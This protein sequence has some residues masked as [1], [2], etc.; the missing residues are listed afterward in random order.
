VHGGKHLQL[1]WR[2]DGH[3]MRVYS[4]PGTPGDWRSLHNTRAQIRRL[5]RADGVLTNP[6]RSDP[7]QPP[8]P[9]R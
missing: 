1:R 5:L 6:E 9:I 3:M 7:P 2:V 8:A 4:V